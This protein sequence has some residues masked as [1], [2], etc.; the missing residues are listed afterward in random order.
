M[1]DGRFSGPAAA[2]VAPRLRRFLNGGLHALTDW[3]GA[4]PIVGCR[5]ERE[6]LRGLIDRDLAAIDR[7]IA[8]QLDA[9]LHHPRLQRLEG[10]WRGLAW[11][12][13]GVDPASLIRVRVL[14]ASWG[15]VGR[16]FDRAIEFDQSAL[17]RMIYEDELGRPGGEPFGLL[18]VDHEMRHRAERRTASGPL[19]V[20][21]VSAL[22]SLGALAAAAF[23]PA[24]V[25][26][27]PALLGVDRFEDLALSFD[28]TTSL[29][30]GDHARW[31]GLSTQDG[32]R[33]LCVTLP[34]VLARPPWA[35]DPARGEGFR[36]AE[37]APEPRDRVWSVAGYAFASV[38][39][40]A[41]GRFHWPAD[42]RGVEVDRLGGGLVPD[43]VVEPFGTDRTGKG[44]GG[45]YRPPLDLT[46]TDAQERRLVEAGL[47]P[48][49]RLPHGNEALF[50]SVRSLYAAPSGETGGHEPGIL[51]A[52]ERISAQINS[53]L[54]VSRFAHYLKVMGREMVGSMLTGG[55]IEQRLQRWLSR[56]TNGSTRAGPD[57]RAQH[58][59]VSSKVSVRE[60]PDRP[61][62]FGCIIHLQPHYQLDDI[63]TTFRLVTELS[64]PGSRS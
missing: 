19:P 53:V 33:F 48:L 5:G 7:L 3:F 46:L 26:A 37:H 13:D 56:Y 34:R 51:A 44:K 50:T 2:A 8:D 36:Y 42:I 25:S 18:V 20:D 54:C 47:I 9:I 45:W 64:V 22:A 32:S 43:L 62:T 49:N 58:P 24:V 38:V 60:R 59:L 21:D 27:S 63:E 55:E 35:A 29:R 12:V 1:L 23:A 61:G 31:R 39:I 16:D 15:E 10:S 57:A 17:F 52:N 28:P 11:L 4:A 14:S 30:D 6:R 41:Q 40:R